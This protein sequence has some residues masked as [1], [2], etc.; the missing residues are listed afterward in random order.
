MKWTYEEYLAQPEWFV[1]FL[2]ELMRAEAKQQSK[3]GVQ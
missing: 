3:G 2:V 1:R